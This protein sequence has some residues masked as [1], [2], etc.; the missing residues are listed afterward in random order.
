[1]IDRST[2]ASCTPPMYDIEHGLQ[3]IAAARLKRDALTRETRGIADQLAEH[4]S[5]HFGPEEMETAGLAL[6]LVAASLG[7]LAA[8]PDMQ[9]QVLVNLAAFAGQR[10][11]GDARAAEESLRG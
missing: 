8:A 10:M 1:M 7:S 11:V 5:R 6:V 2:P 9:P 4:V 3:E